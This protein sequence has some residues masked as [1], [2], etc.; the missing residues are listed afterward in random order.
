[1]EPTRRPRV[2][3]ADDNADNRRVVGRLLGRHDVDATV[4][5]G[6]HEALARLAAEPF[7]VLFLDGMM[8]GLDGP[9]TARE[10]RRR[11]AAAGV[12][13]IAIV[14]LTA[15]SGPDDLARMLEAGMDDLVVKP[16]GAGALERALD[17]WLPEPG[18]RTTMIPAIE[19]VAVDAE[20]TDPRVDP[21]AFGRLAA[22]GDVELADR[23]VGVFL[24][25]ADGRAAQVDAAIGARDAAGAR[26]A[27][28]AIERIGVLVGA[29]ALCERVRD[30]DGRLE[31]R[32]ATDDPGWDVPIGPTGLAPLVAATRERLRV[33][34]RPAPSARSPS[35]LASRGH[36]QQQER[37]LEDVHAR[38][39]ERDDER[40]RVTDQP[41]ASG[42][43]RRDGEEHEPH[44]A[45]EAR[46]VGAGH[47]PA[48]RPTADR[49]ALQRL[50]QEPQREDHAA[51]DEGGAD[52]RRRRR[53]RV[54]QRA[55][56][57]EERADDKGQAAGEQPLHV[58]S[59]A[60]SN[61]SPSRIRQARSEGSPPGPASSSAGETRMYRASGQNARPRS[62]GDG[63]A[64]GSDV[65]VDDGPE[66]LA[67][68]VRLD[69]QAERRLAVDDVAVGRRRLVAA[70]GIPERLAALGDH[71]APDHDAARLVRVLSRGPAR[72]S[73]RPSPGA[74]GRSTA[75]D[76]RRSGS[77]PAHASLELVLH[78]VEAARSNVPAERYFQPPSGSS[79]T[80]VPA[81]I[82]VASRAAATSTAPDDGPA[83]NA[84]SSRRGPGA[85]PRRRGSRTR[86]FASST[87]RVEDLGHEAL[88]ERPQAQK[89]LPG[90]RLRGDDP[91]A[92]PV[93]AQVAP[94]AHQRPGCPESRHEHVDLRA[95]R[96]DLGPGGLVVRLRVGGVAVLV[97]H[98]VPGICGGQHA[99][100]GAIAPLE[101]FVAGRVDDLGAG[102]QPAAAARSVTLSGMTSAI[103][104]RCGG[105]H[106]E[107]DAG[108][109]GGRLEDD[110]VGAEQR[111]APRSSMRYLARGP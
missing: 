64:R 52:Q 83:N 59:S 50:G 48:P 89:L 77:P 15:S 29:T 54:E 32:G 94:G 49:E 41:A 3:V 97:G 109:A 34:G 60:T 55:V 40:Q 68:V 61:A 108:V 42:R 62:V 70:G 11:E 47:R 2:L 8:P 73:R 1:M 111:Q 22:I 46:D 96:E 12:P 30:F 86:Y 33:A 74:F 39:H 43:E 44:A 105:D 20:A 16:I 100:R 57:A 38:D 91:D 6:G 24:S 88:L 79:A 7:D 82:R 65:R 18:R 19:G 106:G 36:D 99:W 78:V 69:R 13:R 14:A 35:G 103:G 102:G 21:S 75:R 98:H 23:L 67:S 63:T 92:R 17:R 56:P 71:A 95:V 31:G 107:G 90:E 85:L 4:V 10:I 28:A 51:G 27:L 25:D 80:I 110:R 81:A 87:G 104:N 66:L 9:A 58:R 26:R 53:D 101:P 45:D 72:R 76:A 93:L 5:G 84:L 37:R